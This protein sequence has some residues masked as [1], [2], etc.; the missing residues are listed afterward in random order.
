MTLNWT[1]V[2]S[3]S[4][5]ALK[6]SLLTGGPYAP[7]TTVS[8]VTTFADATVSNGMTY[9]YIVTAQIGSLESGASNEAVATPGP[10]TSQALLVVGKVKS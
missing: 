9:Y 7:V 2:P 5:Y 1:A 3:A 8:G 6:R 10:V 4:G